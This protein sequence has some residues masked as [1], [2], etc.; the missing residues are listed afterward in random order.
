M[1]KPKLC[2]EQHKADKLVLCLA[3]DK[4]PRLPVSGV[5]SLI[6]RLGPKDAGRLTAAA[7]S[8]AGSPWTPP[9]AGRSAP[10]SGRS[11]GDQDWRLPRTHISPSSQAGLRGSQQGL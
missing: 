8:C 2:Y 10:G 1:E 9:P 6:L 11:A 3:L 5:C 4:T 7:A